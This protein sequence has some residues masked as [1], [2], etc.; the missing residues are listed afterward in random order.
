M[1][2]TFT[3][4][5]P[6]SPG[7][8]ELFEDDTA[9][10]VDRPPIANFRHPNTPSSVSSTRSKAISALNQNRQSSTYAAKNLPFLSVHCSAG[11]DSTFVGITVPHV[12][13]DGH[14]IGMIWNFIS[15]ELSGTP[16][17]APPLFT[18]NLLV[19]ALETAPT[20]ACDSAGGIPANRDWT[21]STF[22]SVFKMLGSFAYEFLWHKAELHDMRIGK[23]VADFL[24]RRV[25]EEVAIKSGGKEWVSTADV[26][27]GFFLKVS[28]AC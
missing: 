3:S 7:P 13:F 28:L 14:G 2:H 15:A 26:M 11:S 21:A 16:W 22:G 17:D 19:K 24:V 27:C 5:P 4:G 20:P 25:K 9:D 1:T 18:E 6:H 12:C 8:L 23:D 10:V